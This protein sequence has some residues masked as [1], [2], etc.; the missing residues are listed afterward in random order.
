MSRKKY[1]HSEETKKKISLSN[2]GEKSSQWKGDNIKYQ[3]IHSWIRRYHSKASKCENH[4]CEGKS[5]EFQWCLIK[6][7]NYERKGEIYQ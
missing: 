3:A 4:L 6:G 1:T 5:K 7:M 2:S